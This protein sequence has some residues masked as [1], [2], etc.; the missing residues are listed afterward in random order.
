MEQK[1]S[2]LVFTDLSIDC[3][4]KVM[5]HRSDPAANYISSA[6]MFVQPYLNKRLEN[7]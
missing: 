4:S 7:H 3:L 1:L 5:S 6:Q 2:E